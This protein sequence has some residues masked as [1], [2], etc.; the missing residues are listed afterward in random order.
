MSATKL[1]IGEKQDLEL[2]VGDDVIDATFTVLNSDGS[3]YDF[4]GFTDINFYIYDYKARRFLRETFVN[5]T[6]LSISSNVITLKVDYSVDVDI[7]PRLYY[8]KMT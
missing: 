1:Y 3:S 8:F 7:L 5:T 6:N 4:T 2:L